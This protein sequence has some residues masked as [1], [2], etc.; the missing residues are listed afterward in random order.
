MFKI[1]EPL[2]S[3]I[4]KEICTYLLIQKWLPIRINSGSATKE[5]RFFRSYIIYGITKSRKS[6]AFPD[7]I[8]LKDNKVLL[9]EIKRQ[10]T[11][12]SQDQKYFKTYVKENYNID[13]NVVR[14]IADVEKV[15]NKMED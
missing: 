7:V 4:Q 8:A 3:T 10:G 11:Y 1:R 5:R 14:C 2:E 12:L 13:V 6:K 15:L 9:F